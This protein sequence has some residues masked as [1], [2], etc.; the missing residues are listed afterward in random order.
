MQACDATAIQALNKP[1]ISSDMATSTG[2]F[3]A[4]VAA[5]CFSIAIVTSGSSFIATTALPYKDASGICWG[6]ASNSAATCSASV[7][8]AIRLCACS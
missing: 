3:Q 4:A 8:D 5:G 6:A 1:R 2:V 7:S